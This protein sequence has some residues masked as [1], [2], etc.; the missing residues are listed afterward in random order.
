MSFKKGR[1]LCHLKKVDDG[2]AYQTVLFKKGSLHD[3]N[4]KKGR[5]LC[6]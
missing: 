4:I 1:R 6:H 5:S 3:C 2:I